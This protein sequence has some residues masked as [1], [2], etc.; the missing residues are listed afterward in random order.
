LAAAGS[1]PLPPVLVLWAL[2]GLGIGLAHS[3][4]GAIACAL[5][6]EGE[7]GAVSS[8]LLI[9]DLF[10]PAVAIGV[11]GALVSFGSATQGGLGLG[12]ALALGIGP[13]LLIL[14]LFSALRLPRGTR[15]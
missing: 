4:S 2:A 1:P 10:G 9:A 8:S 14:S 6:P 15:A 12:V 7:E 13:P 3:V 11:G 5:A